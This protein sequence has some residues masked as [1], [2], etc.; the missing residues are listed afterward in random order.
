MLN[1][2]G[3]EGGI[4]A[5]VVHRLAEVPDLVWLMK[6]LSDRNVYLVSLADEIDTRPFDLRGAG[7]GRVLRA[8]ADWAGAI[9]ARFQEEEE[10][11]AAEGESKTEPPLRAMTGKEIKRIK[12]KLASRNGPGAEGEVA[13]TGDLMDWVCGEFGVSAKQA[14]GWLNDFV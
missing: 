10:A 13:A 11:G 2:L 9:D 1:R 6:E 4:Q 12:E 7:Q 5:V 14:Q 8:V 3:S